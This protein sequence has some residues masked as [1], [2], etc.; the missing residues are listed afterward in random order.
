MHEFRK[1]IN[2]IPH[3]FPIFEALC[4]KI[5]DLWP[6]L[7]EYGILICLSKLLKDQQIKLIEL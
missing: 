3:L 2:T 6:N 1:S 4:H 7:D 5:V